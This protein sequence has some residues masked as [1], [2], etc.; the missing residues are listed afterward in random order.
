[1]SHWQPARKE[2][3]Q[4][5]QPGQ[6]DRHEKHNGG[7][8][9]FKK[10]HIPA[11]PTI[12]LQDGPNIP[13]IRDA[14]QH[15]TQR[16]I[17]EI[18]DI[19][20]DGRYREPYTA[21][22]SPEDFDNDT[23]GIKKQLAI[24][25][26]KREEA[27]Y[28]AYIKSKGKL[29]SVIS[30]IT[31]RDLDERILAH[32]E[33]LSISEVKD[34]IIG[35]DSSNQITASARV[36][37]SLSTTQ[38]PLFLW[39]CI[40]HVTTTQ[41]IG[42]LKADQ[43]NIHVKFAN[44]KQTPGEP[45]SEYKR[46]IVNIL[47]SYSALKLTKPMDSEVATRFLFGLDDERYESLKV[48][49]GNE[50]A[51]DR[52]LYPTTLDGAATQATKWIVHKASARDATS[53]MPT[54]VAMKG[55]G[56]QAPTMNYTNQEA[57][58]I[59]TFCTRK[60]HKMEECFKFIDAQKT[61]SAKTR[62][63]KSRGRPKPKTALLATGEDTD[64][65]TAEPL[66]FMSGYY[67]YSV[68]VTGSNLTPYDLILDTGASGSIVNNKNLLQD[69][70]TMQSSV[71]FGGIAGTLTALQR[72]RVND[73]CTAYY[74]AEAPANIISFSQLYNE[75]HT[76]T[77]EADNSFT[78]KTTQHTYRFTHRKN[79]LYICRAK[80]TTPLLITS[81]Q[82]NEHHHTKR[83]VIRAKE[84]RSLQQ[85]LA[86]PPD[87]RMA[88]A[89][90]HGNII[91]DRVLPADIDRARTIYGP[92]SN[93]LQGRTTTA[94]PLPF[95]EDTIPRIS[96]PQSMYADIFSACGVQFL[97]T[98]T[99]PLDHL[100]CTF[101]E[102]RDTPSMRTALN[103]HLDFYGQRQIKIKTLYSDNERGIMALAS[104][105]SAAGIT[106]TTCGPGMH[107][108]T[109]ERAIRYV[110]E[111]VR[112]VLHGLPYAC[113]RVLFKMLIPYVA[114]R[115]NMFPSTTRTDRL[116]AF[117]LVYNRPAHAD[118]DCHLEY[119]AYYH[120]TTRTSNN[121]MAARTVAAIGVHQIPNGTGSCTFFSLESH[122][123]FSANHF[124]PLPMTQA[125]I[126]HLNA[127]AAKDRSK[128]AATAP[129][130]I[131]DRLLPD[132]PPESGDPVGTTTTGDTTPSTA[133]PE[134][135]SGHT[136]GRTEDQQ[137]QERDSA[138]EGSNA[139]TY[140]NTYDTTEEVEVPTRTHVPG[141]VL[142]QEEHTPT[143][144]HIPGP[145]E[146]HTPV[147]MQVT[148]QSQET[149]DTLAPTSNEREIH[150]D[151]AASMGSNEDIRHRVPRDKPLTVPYAHPQRDR[152]P[153]TK[154][155]LLSVYHITA[156]R[157]LRESPE[158]ARPAIESELRTLVS[159]G[160]FRPVHISKLTPFQRANI[161]RSQLNVTQKFLPSSDGTGRVKDKIKARLVGG[162]DCQDRNHYS[163]AETSSPTIST[164]SIFIIAQEAAARGHTVATIDIG[165]A[166]LNATM[167]KQDPKK[168]VFMRIKKEVTSILTEI[169]PAFMPFTA[170][171][172]TLVVELDKALY[173]CIQSALL[174]YQELV[175]FLSSIGFIPNP[176]DICVLNSNKG[177]VR[178]TIG[179]YVD[180][181]I[182]TSS[183]PEAVSETIKAIQDKYV[184]LKIHQGKVHN[185][186]G[187]VMD[188]SEIGYVD[189]N[190]TGMIHEI[191][192]SSGVQELEA[193]V[194]ATA[195]EPKTP[196]H[197]K[198]FQQG[199]GSALLPTG[200]AK[201]LHSLTAKI[202]FIANRG[203]PDVITFISYMTKRVLAPTIED[204]KKLLRAI[205][206]LRQTA[207][208]D[209]RLGIKGALQV[210]AYIDASFAVHDDMKSHSGTAITLGYG[211]FYTKSTAQKLN[212]TSSCEA[213]LVALSKGMQ[214]A[215]WSQAF[216][217]AQ[218]GPN[219]PIKV[220]Q[221]NQS[222]IQLI[223]RGRPGAEQSRHINIGYFWLHD[224]IIRGLI[225]L[226]YCPTKL[227][228]A[229]TLTKP[230]QGSLFTDLRDMLL[231]HADLQLP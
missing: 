57:N 223:Q 161:I 82:Q 167:P 154:L 172:G 192:K 120:V 86:N 5:R 116:S 106:P 133:V 8:S 159:K 80:Q 56:E 39:K 175:S 123:F 162:G 52:D 208:L 70:I 164:S 107:V 105:L 199:E 149:E 12:G 215:L 88:Q 34:M 25:R 155:N 176:Y 140:D 59:C 37:A 168:L 230:V 142:T 49:L 216:I 51:N 228:I 178:T 115:L 60:G 92:N 227:M 62:A 26:W 174:W 220:Y 206:Y 16:E 139:S 173:G 108:H 75:G 214:Q 47:D 183:S 98:L 40:I 219:N 3:A 213:E 102:N 119:G 177:G 30:S 111:A 46:R 66:A 124:E 224:L 110:K 126:N 38:C 137:E 121:T 145:E 69:T 212:T 23:T 156:K 53:N 65:S 78:V 63:P 29:F 132:T 11:L 190:Q 146:E 14:L 72:G 158:T 150:T 147:R 125:V 112:S 61:A 229:D 114:L 221:D 218:G 89:I 54:F 225:T 84:A 50:A 31:T 83:E 127:L 18:A 95:P 194:G 45:V 141:P 58:D 85:R 76:I 197:D 179:V 94:R 22:Y 193:I 182:I 91:S 101:I 200:L 42:N 138:T 201:E 131:G 185:Y 163:R 55:M 196:S 64:T 198:L 1:M 21:T 144:E 129:F 24:A 153:P 81:V 90:A 9:G 35:V 97:I 151:T 103:K 28:D 109:V 143:R 15:Y 93:G 117:Q 48:Y 96:D 104:D 226:I 44:I 210:S 36:A 202:L 136:P 43:N 209:L 207:D 68:N 187:M 77:M 222:T 122:T 170:T 67:A 99:K 113:P 130:Y 195:K 100:L 6:Q 188:F 71:T 181:L 157:A 128:V 211:A 79:G 135:D 165:S 171:D 7:A 74:H 231:G 4:S 13:Y 205:A 191:V 41:K 73:L 19:F 134:L 10:I 184:Q 217:H 169:E 20:T 17:G 148:T 160:V 180:D 32:Q 27:D 33:S 186:L 166:Y 118:R 203:R 152:R 189:V 204:G 2:Q 87:A